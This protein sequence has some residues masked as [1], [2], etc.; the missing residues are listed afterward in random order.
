MIGQTFWV[1]HCADTG[2]EPSLDLSYQSESDMLD[3]NWQ[4]HNDSKFN[5]K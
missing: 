2:F 3:F 5:D 4:I 1:V